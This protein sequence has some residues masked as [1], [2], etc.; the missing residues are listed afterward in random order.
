MFQNWYPG[1]PSEIRV[2]HPAFIGQFWGLKFALMNVSS[3]ITC[4]MHSDASHCP[5][6][7]NASIL[8]GIPSI[9]PLA[10]T[11]QQ[12]FW[13]LNHSQNSTC[14]SWSHPSPF[15]KPHAR[16]LAIPLR[17]PAPKARCSSGKCRQDCQKQR[18][19]FQA[20]KGCERRFS[21]GTSNNSR[22]FQFITC[23]S[24]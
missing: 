7:A 10:V 14:C 12:N 5:P 18:F 13:R 11:G 17:W 9:W 23:T 4:K 2:H 19:N 22:E 16:P 15:Q 8:G 3:N 1:Y 24:R 6:R 21:A 20:K